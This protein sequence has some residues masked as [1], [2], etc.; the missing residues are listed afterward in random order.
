MVRTWP[1]RR[2]DQRRGSGRD[3]P[4]ARSAWPRAFQGGCALR[5]LSPETFPRKRFWRFVVPETARCKALVG[6]AGGLLH[7]LGRPRHT[8]LRG[9]GRWITRDPATESDHGERHSD[10]EH[11]YLDKLRRL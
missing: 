9:C 3:G 5:P 7:R 6:I 10:H 4:T 1:G 11:P 8:L 2:A